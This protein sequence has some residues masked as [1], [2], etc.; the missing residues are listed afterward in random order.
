MGGGMIRGMSRRMSKVID[1]IL[2]LGG[3]ASAALIVI[4]TLMLIYEVL[5]RYFFQRPSIWA[6]DFTRYAIL[7]LTFLG[8]AWLLREE[9]HV[10]IEIITASFSSKGQALMNGVTSLIALVACC[11][12]FWEATK[13]TWHAYQIGQTLERSL[14]VPR[15]LIIGIMPLGTFLLCLQFMRRAW[16][17][18]RAFR[19]HSGSS[20]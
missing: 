7:Y 2:T 19:D 10:K 20:K 3:Y 4:V 13:S 8:T 16:A 15:Y 1:A 17:H 11:I 14:V 18:F 12:F 5:T 6:L 9:G